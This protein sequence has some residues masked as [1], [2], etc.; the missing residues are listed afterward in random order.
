MPDTIITCKNFLEAVEAD[1]YG[2]KW[3]CKDGGDACIYRHMLPMG[4]ILN[5]D[6]GDKDEGEDEQT[7]EEKIEEERALLDTKN[8]VMV[9]KE[10]FE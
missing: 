2:Y 5:R 9:T 4:Y 7:L 3:V 8:Q 1:M 6:K 10:S